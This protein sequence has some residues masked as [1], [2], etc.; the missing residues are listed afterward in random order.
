MLRLLVG[1]G[2]HGEL[3]HCEV[4]NA[5]A[6]GSLSKNCSALSFPPLSAILLNQPSLLSFPAAPLDAWASNQSP[7]V[8]L[9]PS[10]ASSI[11]D[12]KT[13]ALNRGTAW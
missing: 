11:F 1:R 9:I 3:M 6:C 5:H 12:T 8:S 4:S 10:D 13:T 7:S 2:D